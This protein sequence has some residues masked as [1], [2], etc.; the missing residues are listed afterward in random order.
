MIDQKLKYKRLPLFLMALA[1]VETG[2]VNYKN[3]HNQRGPAGI[4]MFIKSTAQSLGLTVNKNV[5]Q[6]LIPE[7][8]TE[9]AVRLFKAYYKKFKN[10]PLVILAYNRRAFAV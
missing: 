4:W 7:L 2:P 5:D 1:I 3:N 8:Q 9:A 6:R 10:W